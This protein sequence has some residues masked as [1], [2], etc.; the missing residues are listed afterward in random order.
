[1]DDSQTAADLRNASS[2]SPSDHLVREFVEH[3][4]MMARAWGINPTMGELFALLYITGTDW[5]AEELRQW[6]HV[7]RGNVSMNLRE[8]LAWGVVRKLHRPGERRELFHAETEVW[9]LFRRILKERK[10]RELD[11]TL[12]VLDRI[13]RLSETEPELRD[14]KTRVESL[15]HFFGLIDGLAVR[16]LSLE[17]QELS[18]LG[19]LLGENVAASE[20]VDP[21]GTE[22]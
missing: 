20:R 12:M 7:S 15:R 4:G 9:T 21:D 8:L 19:M 13:S 2:A 1:M 22:Q 18:D 5:T 16:L 10:R 11:P 14:L 6:L 17:T 3:W